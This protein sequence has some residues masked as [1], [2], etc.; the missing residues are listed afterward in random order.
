MEGNSL[1]SYREFLESKTPD[2]KLLGFKPV[3]IPDF[4]FDFQRHLVEWAVRQGRCALFEDCGLGKSVQELVW[5]ENILRKEG[6]SVLLLT[7]LA[8]GMQMVREGEK[9]GIEVN[10]TRNGEVRRGINV[11]N[12]QQL[13]KYRP[14]DFVAVIADESSILKNFDGKTRRA[15]TEFFSKVKYRLLCT[16]TP[17][18]NDFMELGSSSEALGAMGRNS[19]LGMFFT[20]DGESTQQWRLKGH[21]RTRFWQWMATW[22]RAV[23]KPSDLGFDDGKFK[24]PPLEVREHRVESPI[25]KGQGFF[26]MPALGLS[27]QRREKRDTLETRC[28]KV[29][30]ILPKDKS[31][32]AWCQLNDEADLLEELIP[33]AVQVAGSD[34]DEQ[35]EEKLNAFPLGQ[36]RVLVSKPTIAGFGLNYQHCSDVSYFPTHSH[37]QF[38]QAIRRCWRFGQGNP[39]SCNLVYSEAEGEILS[40]MLRKEKAAKDMYAGICREMGSVLE[41]RAESNGEVDV[42][43]PG[44][45][46]KFS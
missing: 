19:M 1:S 13:H 43:I 12:Y 29:A 18:P 4:L 35:K 34:P 28:E 17:A 32:I 40:N 3:W 16:A 33:G 10:R 25:R 46:G 11:T 44:W 31:C 8:V 23:R 45:L 36:I 7:P 41:R 20:N 37:E 26:A 14:E 21:A 9:F 5:A 22:A 27:E 39:V 2:R 6:G 24:L 38:Y 30:E 42:E 15:I